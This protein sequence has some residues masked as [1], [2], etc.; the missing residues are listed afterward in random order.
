MRTIKRQ[1]QE[2]RQWARRRGCKGESDTET[3]KI[4]QMM[5]C[6]REWEAHIP[7]LFR[8]AA[9]ALIADRLG[10]GIG[11]REGY[12]WEWGSA[13]AGYTEV[14]RRLHDRN[15]PTKSGKCTPD[16]H[17]TPDMTRRSA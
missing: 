10:I 14:L 15:K 8:T 17:K 12:H 5:R 4:G 9:N 2:G 11:I 7:V 6:L 3:D 16:Q 13:D 1:M